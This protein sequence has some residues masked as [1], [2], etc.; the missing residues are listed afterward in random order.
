M[1]P[2]DI[3]VIILILAAVTVALF[4]VFKNRGKCSGGCEGCAF[5]GSCHQKRSKTTK[6]K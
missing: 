1:S 5:S 6:R 3:I 4:F 2:Q